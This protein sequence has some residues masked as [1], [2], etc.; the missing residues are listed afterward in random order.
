MR[1]PTQSNTFVHQFGQFLWLFAVVCTH[2][3]YLFDIE[4]NFATLR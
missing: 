4:V 2:I 1:N 3:I